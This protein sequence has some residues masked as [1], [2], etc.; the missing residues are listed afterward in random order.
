M[1]FSGRPMIEN[2]TS[3]DVLFSAGE[4]ESIKQAMGQYRSLSWYGKAVKLSENESAVIA[5]LLK[6]ARFNGYYTHSIWGDGSIRWEV[7][8]ESQSKKLNKDRMRICIEACDVCSTNF[9]AMF[10]PGDPKPT[11]CSKCSIKKA[12]EAWKKEVRRKS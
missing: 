2:A 10:Y 6:T 5:G 4:L 8:A 7:L 12:L 3:P 11:M 9:H 1:Q